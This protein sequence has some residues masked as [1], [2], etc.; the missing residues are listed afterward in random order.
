MVVSSRISDCSFGRAAVVV[1]A[2]DVE[3]VGD[4]VAVGVEQVD[5]DRRVVERLAQDQVE[6][7]RS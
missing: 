5:V 3:R 2:H 1:Q 7:A 4:Q 6:L